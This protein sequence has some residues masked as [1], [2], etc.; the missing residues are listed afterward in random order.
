MISHDDHVSAQGDPPGDPPGSRRD[1]PTNASLEKQ[2]PPHS[3]SSWAH[4]GPLRWLPSAHSAAAGN[5]IL[6]LE[7]DRRDC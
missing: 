5:E 2:L 7:P 1:F 6:T 4:F 3:Q